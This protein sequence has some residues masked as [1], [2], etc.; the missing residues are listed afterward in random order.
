MLSTHLL[1]VADVCR[2]GQGDGDHGRADGFDLTLVVAL[3]YFGRSGALPAWGL[4]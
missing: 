1:P 2:K 3:W 4:M